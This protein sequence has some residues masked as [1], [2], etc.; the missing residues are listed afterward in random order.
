MVDTDASS[1]PWRIVIVDD[2]ADDRAEMRS[3]L[4]NGSARRYELVDAETG[5]EA[6]AAALDPELGPPSCILL[7]YFLPDMDG[8]EVLKKLLL[9][10]GLLVCPV[11]VITGADEQHGRAVLRLGAQDYIGK[12]GLM[13]RSLTRSVEHAVERWT[14]ANELRDRDALIRKRDE[15]IAMASEA[16]GLMY[17]TWD[18]V[19]D[20]GERRMSSLARVASTSDVEGLRSFAATLARVDPRDRAMFEANVSAALAGHGAYENEFRVL[21]PD[22]SVRSLR[23]RGRV[24]FD[25]EGRPVG[26][27][28][29]SLD[30]TERVQLEEQ[31]RELADRERAARLTGEDSLRAKDV[32]LAMLGHE[33]RNPLA[34]I[35]T[36]LHLMSMRGPLSREAAVIER[37]TLHL[38]RLVDDL[39]DVSRV[40]RGK[41]NLQKANV[42]IADLVA[43][44]VEMAS[45]EIERQRQ[46]LVI[47]VPEQGL[48]ANVDRMRMTQVIAN[49]LTNAAKYTPPGGRVELTAA[50]EHDE[51]VVRVRDRG[52]GIAADLLPSIFDLFVQAPQTM[53]RSRGGLGV[54]L[55][56][57]KSLVT[58]HGGT[59]SA[60]SEGVGHG[61]T[62]TVRIPFD[63]SPAESATAVT[64][65]PTRAPF[66]QRVLVVDDNVDGAVLLSEALDAFGYET[67]VAHDPPRALQLAEA[68]EP[69]IAVLDIGLPIMDGYELGGR[70]RELLG[71]VILV[72]VTGYGSERD[73]RRAEDAGFHAH[74]TKPVDSD[75]LAERLGQLEESR[76]GRPPP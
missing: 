21:E 40:T 67:A 60:E 43:D 65:S 51:I 63:P 1:Q 26:L 35:V 22:G 36:A 53:A 12:E 27:T 17:F 71:D 5:A 29:A 3:L 69:K 76:T 10:S 75:R 39:L 15:Q 68:F 58:L 25:G 37:Q 57:V 42:E 70:L 52:L 31:L 45:P 46:E 24:L 38:S 11:V 64:P 49:I 62:F 13:P 61:S 66:R 47:Q 73:R 14:R 18:V 34:P 33:L 16:A 9:P 74:F 30:I 8:Q 19:E 54:G 50:R 48:S 28:G 55:A 56:I 20:R 44:A 23:D 4:R 2:N 7:D 41:V 32:F 59:V 6:V 72:A